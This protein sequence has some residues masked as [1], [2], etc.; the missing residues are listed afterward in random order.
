MNIR[1]R[2]H[3]FWFECVLT[4]IIFYRMSA[5]SSLFVE[6]S[7]LEIVRKLA[8]AVVLALFLLDCFVSSKFELSWFVF[9]LSILVI[10]FLV[11]RSSSDFNIVFFAVLLVMARNLQINDILEFEWKCLTFMLLI[12]LLLSFVGISPDYA[13]YR[14]VGRIAHTFGFTYYSYMP[15]YLLYICIMWLYTHKSNKKSTLIWLCLLV[16]AYIATTKFLTLFFGIAFV[17]F[18]FLVDVLKVDFGK[19]LKKFRL[20]KFFTYALFPAMIISFV[21]IARNYNN[22]NLT[23]LNELSHNRIYYSFMGLKN[24]GI[25][26]LGNSIEMYG[27]TSQRY[28]SG[29]YENFYLDSGLLVLLLKYGLLIAVL[30]YFAY[31][32][33]VRYAICDRNQRMLFWCLMILLYNIGSNNIIE[34]WFNPILLFM[35]DA[36]YKTKINLRI[37]SGTNRQ[38]LDQKGKM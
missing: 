24:Y 16:S 21:V 17:L 36:H 5:T 20:R 13:Y 35:Y 32:Q 7:E 26:F 38:T 31:F 29:N 25:S 10:S 4:C 9:G 34:V 33:V 27:G 6:H 14:G 28:V 18:Y 2:K 3:L 19:S 15:M 37:R 12:F 11:Y 8:L 22:W 23:T 30:V 1:I